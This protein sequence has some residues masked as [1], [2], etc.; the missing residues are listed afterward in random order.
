MVCQ[1]LLYN[2]VNQLYI[3]IYSHI[4]SLLR[5]PP[6]LPIPPLQVV[7]KHQADLPELISLCYAAASHQLSLLH[8]VVYV[9]QCKS[10]TSSHLTLPPPHVL[11]SILYVCVFTPVLPLGSSKPFFSLDFKMEVFLNFGEFIDFFFFL[12]I[13]LLVYMFFYRG[14]VVLVLTFGYITHFE[15][16]FM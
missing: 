16:I 4:P 11:K 10:L 2:R 3:Y 12:Q 15:L 5:L 14:F 7:T 8:L 6:T 9:C 13:I 1:F